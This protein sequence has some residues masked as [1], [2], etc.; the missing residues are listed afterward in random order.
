MKKI[1]LTLVQIDN[2]GPWTITPEPRGEAELQT[3]Q[4]ELFAELERQFAYH[5]GLAFQTRF[6]NMLAITNG[7]SLDEH[8]AIQKAVNEKFP[9]TVSMSVGT[10]RTP[11]EAQVQAT[12]TLQR[13]GSSRSAERSGALVGVCV[14][15]P[16]KDWVELAHMDVNHSAL[17]T[18]SKPIYDTHLFLQRT[19]LS[20]MSAL[21]KRNALVF[22]TGGD[23]FMVPSNGLNLIE[24]TS[25][26]S[27]V[28][29][30]VGVDLKAGVGGARTAEIAAHLASEGLH[31]IR[32]GVVKKNIVYKA[33]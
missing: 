20:L 14:N 15:S 21:I 11:Y 13:A 32:K 12:I 8:R 10:A 26:F 3:L 19:Y 2:Y 17:F 30:E 5:K 28:K 25:V 7:I 16:D 1:Q 23:N 9:V 27:E 6:D 18:D 24:L 4:A 29:R 31:E 33:E 22:Y